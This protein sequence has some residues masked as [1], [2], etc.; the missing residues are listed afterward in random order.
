M[1]ATFICRRCG[2]TERC[3]CRPACWPVAPDTCSRCA[4]PAQLVHFDRYGIPKPGAQ[5]AVRARALVRVA[6]GRGRA[7]RRGGAS[8]APIRFSARACRGKGCR[9]RRPIGRPF[10][11][12]CWKRIDLVTRRQLVRLYGVGKPR[13]GYLAAV[14]RANLQISQAAAAEAARQPRA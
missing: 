5:A 8:A 3:P 13:P 11:D 1:E 10:C 4:T 9:G 14:A 7:G 12:G 2:C 6:G